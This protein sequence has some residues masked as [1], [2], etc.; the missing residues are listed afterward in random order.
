MESGAAR[1]GL[2]MTR[3]RM[4]RSM[5]ALLK[6]ADALLVVA[7]KARFEDGS[8]L[9]CLP[10]PLMR[11]ALDL[12][13][14]LEP[15]R[16]GLAAGTLTGEAPR[17][18]AVGVLPDEVSRHNSPARAEA[19]RRVVAQS[20]TGRKGSAAILL[21]LDD[22]E[23]FTAAMGAVGKA[24]PLY[25]KPARL[26]A[27]GRPGKPAAE[28][29]LNVMAI[30]PDD[31]PIAPPKTIMPTVD[32]ARLAA[33]L[34]DV[35]P[36][37]L[38]PKAFQAE[39]QKLLR[40][41]TGVTRKAIVGDAL[42]KAGLG[43]IHGVGRTALDAPR[44]LVYTYTPTAKSRA[45][46]HIALV[47]KGVTYDTGGLSLKI[48][49]GMVGMKADMG[50]AA[51][52]LGA[53]HSLVKGGAPCKVSAVNCLAE[54]ALRMHSGMTVEI[55]NTDAEGRLLLADG[56]SYAARNLKAD[57]V[58]DIATLTG[59]QGVA[60]GAMH[61]ALIASD[62]D[63]ERTIFA[64]GRACGD[65]VHPIPYAPEFYRDEFKSQIADM[66]NSV[67]NRMNAQS[68]CAGEFVHWHLDGTDA[69][70]AHVDMAFPAVRGG[71]GTG[72]GVA[73]LTQA[74]RDLAS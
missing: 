22:A 25:R 72:Y 49:G 60:T 23:H 40:G 55:N 54:N 34:V 27:T 8:F 14:D 44:M 29:K 1:Y 58:I 9:D 28:P 12:A 56:V 35:P 41:V 11:L 59:A 69:R 32:G 48:S 5:S 20:S 7:P 43:G 62:E 21:V 74:V 73:L 16:N 47:G 4:T 33:R 6:G 51:A 45:K 46:R 19:I 30:G 3:I 18:L 31:Q 52:V 24:L 10:E 61:G 63:L 71:R 13:S 37:E 36:T 64:A 15:G 26:T 53:F 65:L 39:A 17:K 38:N 42:L 57:T 2:A 50:G 67:A 68:S 70:W 66:K